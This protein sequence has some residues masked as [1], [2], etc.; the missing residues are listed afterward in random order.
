[1]PDV[2]LY[3]HRLPSLFMLAAERVVS[4][5]LIWPLPLLL[6]GIGGVSDPQAAGAA[7]VL[8]ALPWGA[9]WLVFGRPT[10]RA[11]VGG[12]LAL[13]VASALLGM[14]A[15]YDPALSWPM[16]LT[17]LGSASLFFAV[18][19]SPT[20]P[21]RVAEG[22]AVAAGLVAL[23]FVG[24]YAHFDYQEEAGQLARLGRLT[25]SLMPNLV[26]FTPHPNAVASFLEGAFP[27][28]L[29]LVWYRRG[30]V[31][32][33]WGT[34]A[35]ITAYGLLISQSRGAWIGLGVALV[36][37][38]LLRL[39]SWAERLVVGSLVLVGG[40]LGLFAVTRLVPT[41]QGILA[42]NSALQTVG[43]R[44][45]LYRN[46][47]YLLGDYPFT[48]IGL[49]DTFAMVYSRYQ[50]LIQVPFLS[51]S[52]NLFLSVGLGQGL[53]GLAALAWLLAGFYYFVGRV[54]RAELDA[55][56]LLLF[57]A[58]WLGTTVTLV[59][60]LTDAPQFSARWTMPMLFALLSL[61]VTVGRS[62]LTPVYGESAG[63]RRRRWAG[64]AAAGVALAVASLV[65]GRPLLSAWYANLGAVYQ[66]RADLSPGLPDATRAEN[67]TRAVWYFEH[68][69]RLNPAQAVANR[70]LG[71]MSME[72][73]DFE[74]AALYLEQAYPHEMANQ[75]TLKALGYAYLWSGRLDAAEV[76]LRQIDAQS[77]LVEELG[78]WTWWWGTQNRADRA[79]AAAEMA[80]RLSSAN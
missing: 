15:A 22:I 78:T 38:V 5:E 10:R 49:G 75:A 66:T 73:E 36:I 18:V 16:L 77:E 71:Q 63:C 46:S 44:L 33:A 64:V 37:G 35:A 26:F 76:L 65:F 80:R 61:A 74:K 9:H 21:W 11:F 29:A 52:H 2:T 54:E 70:R 47:L 23:Y 68:A 24:Q 3:R 62:A 48:G 58:A 6:I 32:M 59:H 42:L 69:L 1:M 4:L 56:S 25:G 41:D 57:R 45:V 14:W 60:G 39:P 12:P 51:Y 50:L 43:S 55:R 79:A 34:A 40:L 20:A 28:T 30:I 7:L 72:R 27:L 19:N 31:R 8:A 13:F 17:V 67:A 53:T